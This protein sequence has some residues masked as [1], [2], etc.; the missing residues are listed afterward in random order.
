MTNL[1][2]VP[3][4]ELLSFQD[5]PTVHSQ[6][7]TTIPISEAQIT[8]NEDNTYSSPKLQPKLDT[9]ESSGNINC[10]SFSNHRIFKKDETLNT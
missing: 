4:E 10:K 9:V 3:T 6:N 1:Q 8:I 7:N 2:E 5:Y